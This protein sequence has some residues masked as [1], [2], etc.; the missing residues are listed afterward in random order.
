[1]NTSNTIVKGC[2]QTSSWINI[3]NSFAVFSVIVLLSIIKY[4]TQND[5]IKAQQ[6]IQNRA[7]NVIL[8]IAYV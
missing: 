3:L 7:N 6:T 1:M 2:N 4:S 8:L 5:M